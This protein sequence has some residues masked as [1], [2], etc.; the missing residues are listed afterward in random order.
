MMKRRT[1]LK[2]MT[3]GV[4]AVN[5]APGLLYGHSNKEASVRL[6]G[7]VFEPYDDPDTWV[8]SL[9]GLGFR[10]A[11]CPVKAGEDESIIR[12]YEK[13]ARENDIV[14]AEVGAWSNT[15][16]SD[17][18]EAKA[19]LEKCIAGLE[20]A[21]QINSRCC[22]N[23]SGSKNSEYWAGPHKDNLTQETFDQVV[24]VTRKIIDAVKPTRTF[25][26]LEAM[27]WAFPDS[28]ETYL[29]LLKAIDRKQFGVHLDPVNMITSVRDY[30]GNG[31]LIKEMF[32]KLGPH[33][34]SC[35]AKDITLRED[36]YIPQ[37]DELRPG[38]GTLD[39]SIY[40]RELSK[41]DEVPL[42]MEHL[43][44]A[45]EYKLAADYIRSVGKSISLNI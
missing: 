2:T 5:L 15:I 1:Y 29:Q 14:I 22:V 9:K 30:Y 8:A 28:T 7:P 38:L 11:Y 24:E 35:H 23:V 6:G 37:L 19:A 27:P 45:E 33:I 13:A 40:L 20:L 39:Y 34:R 43:K 4:A 12:A 18:D 25:F 3:A 41:L 26:A 32:A 36:N 42:M 21:D 31:A 10:A 16:A 17:P 44:T